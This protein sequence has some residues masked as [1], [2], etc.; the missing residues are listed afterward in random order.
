MKQK[1]RPDAVEMQ[2]DQAL[3]QR[4]IMKLL[5]RVASGKK[6]IT[7]GRKQRVRMRPRNNARSV[8]NNKNSEANSMQGNTKLIIALQ[9]APTLTYGIFLRHQLVQIND[10]RMKATPM[11]TRTV[12]PMRRLPLGR[13]PLHVV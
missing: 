7:D 11:T 10:R 4:A 12:T 9:A 2:T 13:S 1:K 3:K 6:R 8:W 5:T